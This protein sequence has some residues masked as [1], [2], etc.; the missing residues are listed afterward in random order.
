MSM[1]NKFKER[2]Y[3]DD[4]GLWASGILKVNFLS[5]A[6]GALANMR[7]I[8]LYKDTVY[9]LKLQ[10]ASLVVIH[11]IRKDDIKSV[12]TKNGFLFLEVIFT[13]E[14]T[15]FNE[16]YKITSNKKAIKEITSH[17]SQIK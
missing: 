2:N 10:N 17:F 8:T 7:F 6:F 9:V 5:G 15:A 1:V 12:H 13:I 16:S 14:T 11:K 4:R 3:V